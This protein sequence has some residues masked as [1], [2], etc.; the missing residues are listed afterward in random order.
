MPAALALTRPAG[1]ARHGG[2]AA[3]AVR[4]RG[5]GRRR[6]IAGD[7]RH[8]LTSAGHPTGSPSVRYLHTDLLGSPV[9][10]TDAAGTV[11][12]IERYTPY[13]EPGDGVMDPGPG[14]T[15]HVTD[16]LTGLSYAQQRYYD[17]LLGRFL[18]PDPVETDANSGG[19]FN[20][21][22]Y[23][24]DNPYRYTDP[25]GRAID[26]VADVAFIGYDIYALITEPSWTNAAALGADVIGAVVPV[27]TG[28]G[29]AVRAGSHGADAV[30]TTDHASDAARS[31]PSS[32]PVRNVDEG[33]LHTR[34]VRPAPGT[35][36][37]PTGVPANWRIRNTRSRGGTEYYDPQNPNESV[38]VMQGNPNS[39][40]PNS[41]APY[42][43]E[44]D[45]TG[46]FLRQDGTPSPEPRGGRNDGDAHI[47]LIEYGGRR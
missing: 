42:V 5:F 16:A 23:A 45:A 47:P 26:V 2:R 21:Y 44:R 27:A 24:N 15:G 19:N 11:T 8:T 31:A 7:A 6:R 38:R 3:G 46:T 37:R 29:T 30:R 4:A 28:L 18:S 34:G 13:G 9:A 17:P 25:D 32:G 43:R 35:R 33:E 36:T 10:E 39:P 40:Y 12:R 14:Y 41:Q 22:W 1:R 20:R